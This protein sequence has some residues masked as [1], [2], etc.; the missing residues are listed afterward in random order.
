MGIFGELSADYGNWIFVNL[1][2][3]N[4]WTSTVEKDNRRIFYPSAS[5]SFV[6]TTLFIGMKSKFL[7]F[8]KLRGGYGTS[9]GFP[10]PYNTRNILD[11]SARG[12][13]TAAGVAV[14]VS[15]THL[16]VYKRQR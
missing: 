12:F 7:N 5:V 14:P 2:A 13:L 11:Q 15:Y 3:R 1:A 9:A 4:D 16:D 10:N 8:L 6:P